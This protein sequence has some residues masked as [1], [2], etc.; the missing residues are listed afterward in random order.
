[1]REHIVI[2]LSYP[3]VPVIVMFVDLV[4]AIK[5]VSIAMPVILNASW[6]PNYGEMD[7]TPVHLV[8]NGKSNI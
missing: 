7:A 6:Y 1:M 3:N 2:E 8:I 5:M 4:G